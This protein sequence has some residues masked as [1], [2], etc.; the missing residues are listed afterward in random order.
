[1]SMIHYERLHKI[2]G[3]YL[4]EA[5]RRVK[6]AERPQQAYIAWFTQQLVA[7]PSMSHFAES[8]GGWSGAGYKMVLK[9]IMRR[10]NVTTLH[11]LVKDK[12]CGALINWMADLWPK[13]TGGRMTE[14]DASRES[15]VIIASLWHVLGYERAGKPLY[16][17]SPGLGEKLVHTRLSG[18]RTDDLRLPFESIYVIMPQTTGFVL[19]DQNTGIHPVEGCYIAE[20]TSE[21]GDRAW[22]ILV[23]GAPKERIDELDDQL[24]YFEIVLPPGKPIDEI[25]DEKAKESEQTMKR[26]QG[27]PLAEWV[28]FQKVW[29]GIFQWLM[30][31][32]IY[33]TMPGADLQ[34]SQ[35][36]E[37]RQLKE[38]ID[39]LPKGEKRDRLRD[40]LKKTD[41]RRRIYVG[42]HVRSMEDE[43]PTEAGTGRKITVRTRVAGHWRNQAHGPR[44]TLHK[45]KWIEPFWRGGDDL[46]TSEPTRVVR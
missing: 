31:L 45:M 33:L 46:V 27:M 15:A 10:N 1:M 3:P 25:I 38:R 32:V 44:W 2:I 37:Y 7:D 30:N 43:C 35:A 19:Y 17:V 36:R 34:E 39:K 41:P 6:A 22:R 16:D 12:D 8:L 20:S 26:G 23:V 29:G 9:E 4:A 24:T 14:E 21:K 11:G 40:E 5:E 42:Q 28:H 13:I 18:V